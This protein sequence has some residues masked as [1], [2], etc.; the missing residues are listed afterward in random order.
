MH[1]SLRKF[2]SL[3]A[4]RKTFEFLSNQFDL[5]PKSFGVKKIFEIFSKSFSGVV[6][7]EKISKI[8]LASK[9]FENISPCSGTFR[10]ACKNLRSKIILNNFGQAVH[11]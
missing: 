3:V 8:F 7:E 2:H 11:A 4:K 5:K 1:A 10:V 6:H 9:D